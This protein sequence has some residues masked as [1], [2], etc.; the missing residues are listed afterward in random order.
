MTRQR[1]ANRRARSATAG[2]LMIFGMTPVVTAPPSQADIFDRDWIIDLLGP[3]L[4]DAVMNLGDASAG[5][6]FVDPAA[7]DVFF[8]NLADPATWELGGTAVALSSDSPVLA[9]DPV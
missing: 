6:T 8:A 7:W 9:S 1:N 4:S 2:A 3:G 5:E